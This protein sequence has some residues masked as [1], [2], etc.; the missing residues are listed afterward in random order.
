MPG[1]DSAACATV[2]P[3]SGSSW[4]M[5]LWMQG[6][7]PSQKIRTKFNY[8]SPDYFRTMGI[9]MRGG[10]DFE[11]GDSATS[12]PVAIV[13][14]A[15]A[16]RFLDGENPVGRT[17]VTEAEPNY[18][19]T[20]CEVVG[21]VKNTKYDD[22][23]EEFKPIAYVPDL[24]HPRPRVTAQLLIRSSQPL[25]SLR[26]GVTRRIGEASPEIGINY[27]EFK[28]VI[29]EG[30]LREQ[31]TAT[32][33]GFFG[34]LALMLACTGLY[35]VISYNVASRT[36]EIGI[37]MAL[38]AQR[39]QVFWLILRETLILVLIGIGVGLP[40]VLAIRNL[41]AGELYDLSAIDPASMLFAAFLMAAV[42]AAAGYVPA[43]QA[44]RLDPMTALRD[45]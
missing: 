28:S 39:G 7:D 2:V 24:Q 43:F 10:R 3:V 21:L 45:E 32:L 17:F 34:L 23:R 14:E 27:V 12:T 33:S 18:P 15:F 4:T 29:R 25:A 8:V 9:E 16:M 20:A 36:N 30:L 37:R 13:N 6:G 19:Q 41:I 40:G 22:L 1:V 35:G 31:L 42:A 44:A 11:H 38:G 5:S 26:S